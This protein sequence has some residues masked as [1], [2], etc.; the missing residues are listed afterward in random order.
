MMDWYNHDEIYNLIGYLMYNFKGS[1][2]SFELKED[3]EQLDE[4]DDDFIGEKEI[5][6]NE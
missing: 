1:K 4:F 2:I 5:E 6:I 3:E